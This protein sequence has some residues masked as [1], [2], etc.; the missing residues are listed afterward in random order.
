MTPNE[1][2]D[3]VLSA[4]L[5]HLSPQL[6]LGVR[7]HRTLR[8]RH[9]QN[10]V[11]AEQVHAHHERVQRSL[12]H[13]PTWI[14]E[15]LRIAR[16]EAEHA[17]R[18][19]PRVHA[20]NDRD[21]CVGDAV[22]PTQREG[23]G[24]R[25]VRRQQIVEL[26]VHGVSRRRTIHAPSRAGAAGFSWVRRPSWRRGPRRGVRSRRRRCSRRSESCR[27]RADASGFESRRRSRSGRCR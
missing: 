26:T 25:P 12:S 20:S 14:A 3:R 22:E 7:R 18:V 23:R 15:D 27:V 8:V 9:D 2:H 4:R 16:L 13:P 6:V 19:E 1:S 11:H 24:E 21:P 17:E 5:T 10:P